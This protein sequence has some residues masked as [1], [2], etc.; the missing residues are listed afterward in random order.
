M[1]LVF[2]WHLPRLVLDPK[3]H[4]HHSVH[5]PQTEHLSVSEAAAILGESRWT[6]QRR[7]R[8]GSLPAER[9][10]DIYVVNRSDVDAL[11]AE[12]SAVKS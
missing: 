7:I 6:T 10:G 11:I 9:V 5:M 3:V 1:Q 4:L 8:A 12:R 2:L